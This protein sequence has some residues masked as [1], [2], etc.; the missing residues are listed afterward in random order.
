MVQN[1]EERKTTTEREKRGKELFF[2]VLEVH[3]LFFFLRS[4]RSF[5]DVVSLSFFCSPFIGATK[6]ESERNIALYYFF[7]SFVF[8]VKK[9]TAAFSVPLF[10]VYSPPLHV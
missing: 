10:Q 7:S 4:P 3:F 1:L 5:F 9:K 2:F 6:K 8:L